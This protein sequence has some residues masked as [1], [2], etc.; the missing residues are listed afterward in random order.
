MGLCVF[1]GE[2]GGERGGQRERGQEDLFHATNQ[3]KSKASA[4]VTRLL[5]VAVCAAACLLHT[6]D[7]LRLHTLEGM[8]V[9]ASVWIVM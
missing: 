5:V 7:A 2:R 8:S 9:V 6:L 4:A 3:A 1:L